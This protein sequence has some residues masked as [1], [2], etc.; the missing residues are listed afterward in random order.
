MTRQPGTVAAGRASQ[1]LRP[2]MRAEAAA[3]LAARFPPRIVP[4]RWEATTWDRGTVTARL[5]AAPFATGVQANICRRR[6]GLIRFLD[7]LGHQPGDTWQQR[8]LASGIAVD[9]RLDWRPPV[10]RWLIRAGRAPAGTA[11]LEASITSGLGQLIYAD[12]LRPSLPWLLASPIR[13]PLGGEMPRVRDSAGFTALQARAVAA[14]IAFHSR[15]RAAEQIAV[16]LAAKGGVIADITVGDC[17]ELMEIRDTIAG[18]LDGGKG[19]GFYQLLHAMGIFPPDAPA[20]LRMLDPRFQG[21]LSTA[22]L[23]DQYALSCQPVRDLLVDYL[24]ERRPALDYATLKTQAYL[25]GKLFWKD[26]ETRNPGISSLR[27]APDVAAAWK[28]R[29]ATKT[30]PARGPA[31]Q[32]TEITAA[33]MDTLSCLTAVRAFYLDIAQWALDDPARWGPWAAP[34]PIRREEVGPARRDARRKSRMDQR[35]RERLPVLPTLVAAAE[36]NLRHT[37]AML[38]AAAAAAPG[39]VFTSGAVTLRR[40]APS[41]PSPRISAEDPA[42]GTRR[43]LTREEEAA[44]WAWAAIEVL[45]STGIR[46][47]ELTELS[48]HSLIQYRLPATGELIPLLH[49]T[50]SKTDVERLLVI[51]PELADVLAAIIHRVRD[52]SGAVPLVIAYD[53]HECEFTPPMPVL[54][55]RRVGT[56]NRP[57]SAATIRRRITGTL[58]GTGLTDASG[59]ALKF[60]PHDFRRIFATEAIMNGLPPHICQLIMGHKNINT[61]MGYKT[62]YPEEV[63]NSHRAFIARRRELRPSSEYRAPTQAEWE[64]F[65]GHFERRKVALGDCGRAWGTSCVHEHSCTR[66]ALLRVDPAQQ[67]RLTGIRDNLIARIAEAQREGWAGE[68]EGL[69]VSLAAANSKLAQIELTTARCHQAISLGMP[70]FRDV[71]DGTVTATPSP[72]TSEGTT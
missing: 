52:D 17:L 53:V 38:A 56:D 21:Q 36:H 4:D 40:R 28:L 7:W 68:A 49:I 3:A 39:E 62:V 66:C 41:I 61:T 54:F 71:A 55:Q 26:L 25:L 58:D 24:S 18:T 45:R 6:L 63:I 10:A 19:A 5:L 59:Q 44:F 13:F 9:G 69:K 72:L 60:T 32:V 23:I 15:R 42:T 47:E 30:V 64:E 67:P 35:T 70:A 22:E 1:P 57:V 20:T 48:H 31:G 29:L 50:P 43:D 16:I 51:S 12:V 46:I 27:L 65:L 8:W 33:R 2:R 34:C 37:A 11:G 14:G